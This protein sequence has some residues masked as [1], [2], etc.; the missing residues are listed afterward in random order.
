MASSKKVYLVEFEPGRFRHFTNWPECQAFVHGKPY[1]YAG[2]KTVEEAREKIARA[3]GYFSSRNKTKGGA[4]SSGAASRVKKPAAKSAAKDAV[5]R[6]PGAPTEGICSDAGTHGNP[7]PSEFQV[8]DLNGKVLVH[9][10]LG[11]RSNNFAELAGIGAMIQYAIEHGIRM[12]WTDSTIAMGWIRTGRVGQTVHDR[13]LVI[14]MAK[15]AKALLNEHPDLELKK[16]H[17]KKWG[18]IPADFGRKS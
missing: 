12:L 18:E 15:K 4:G 6:P 13:E 2:G 8:C 16:W 11:V 10:E 17:T 7:G 1:P 5:F 9:K 3:K 14:K